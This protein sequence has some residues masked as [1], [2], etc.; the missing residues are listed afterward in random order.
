[1]TLS[2]RFVGLL[3]K[4]TKDEKKTF[5]ILDY[6][7]KLESKGYIDSDISFFLLKIIIIITSYYPN[8]ID[9]VVNLLKIFYKSKSESKNDLVKLISKFDLSSYEENVF[10]DFFMDSIIFETFDFLLNVY[11]INRELTI[12]LLNEILLNTSKIKT[13]N[14]ELKVQIYLLYLKNSNKIL[15]KSIQEKNSGKGQVYLKIIETCGVTTRLINSF[16]NNN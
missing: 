15:Q 3:K 11:K 1:M 5:K 14:K 8:E 16:I 7:E 13:S 10:N 4:I 9:K 12:T 6:I 2:D